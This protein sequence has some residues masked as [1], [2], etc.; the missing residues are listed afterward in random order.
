MVESN[1]ST[2]DSKQLNIFRLLKDL[3]TISSIKESILISFSNSTGGWFEQRLP[4]SDALEVARQI[5]K[6]LWEAPDLLEEKWGSRT[7]DWVEAELFC[8][9]WFA[10]F[11][12]WQTFV[13]GRGAVE[14]LPGCWRWSASG[15]VAWRGMGFSESPF[16]DSTATFRV[17]I[18][19]SLSCSR[20]TST[21]KPSIFGIFLLDWNALPPRSLQSSSW[22]EPN[23]ASFAFTSFVWL[24]SFFS[25]IW[26]ARDWSET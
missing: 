16:R 20:E 12:W 4:V 3:T 21:L 7:A 18:W 25:K 1:A 13:E 2:Y 17:G 10:S 24:P 9:A 14:P 5:S 19:Q 6:E 23:M 22:Y 26:R 15:S 8:I 11:D